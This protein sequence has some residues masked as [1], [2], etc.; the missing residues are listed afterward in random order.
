MTFH[1]EAIER[2]TGFTVHD[3]GDRKGLLKLFEPIL[4]RFDV[5]ACKQQLAT[6][7]EILEGDSS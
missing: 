2:G 4:N 5:N 7:R 1:V 6:I 3:K